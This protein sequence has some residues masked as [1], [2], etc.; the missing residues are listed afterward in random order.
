LEQSEQ[1]IYDAKD[2]ETNPEIIKFV[3]TSSKDRRLNDYGRKVIL[4]GIK[5]LFD[6][7]EIDC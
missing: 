6:L 3:P 7:K 5:S 4:M 2:L 1:K